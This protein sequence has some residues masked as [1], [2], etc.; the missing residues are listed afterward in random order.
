[1][2]NFINPWESQNPWQQGGE[3]HNLAL[4]VP[5]GNRQEDLEGELPSNSYILGRRTV[6]SPVTVISQ[7]LVGRNSNNEFIFRT[8]GTD[9]PLLGLG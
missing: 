9:Y 4:D 6:N 2:K 5:V 7:R 8:G 1:M 3:Y